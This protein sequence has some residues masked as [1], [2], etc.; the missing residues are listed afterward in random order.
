MKNKVGRPITGRKPFKVMI[1]P[2][3]EIVKEVRRYAKEIS[4]EFERGKE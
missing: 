3:E 4:E 1:T 2:D